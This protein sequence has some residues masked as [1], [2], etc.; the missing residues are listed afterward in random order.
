M[1][2]TAGDPSLTLPLSA[3][4]AFLLSIQTVNE[5]VR[6]NAS[7]LLSLN[8]VFFPTI[9]RSSACPANYALLITFLN[10][11]KTC[12]SNRISL[13]WWQLCSL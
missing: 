7:H 8:T 10:P 4:H 2:E 6:E 3:A 9:E 5:A 12:F 1:K 13:H 11:Y